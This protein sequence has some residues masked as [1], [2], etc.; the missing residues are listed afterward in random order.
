MIELAFDLASKVPSSFPRHMYSTT[1]SKQTRVL[2]F[3]SLTKN[4]F[5]SHSFGGTLLHQS[6]RIT[7]FDKKLEADIMIIKESDWKRLFRKAI[8]K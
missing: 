3:N 2:K 5:Q 8:V 1:P 7:F 4:L 6:V